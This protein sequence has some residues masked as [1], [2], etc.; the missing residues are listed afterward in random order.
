MED[1]GIWIY[2]IE[3]LANLFTYTAKNRD[4][5]EIVQ[6]VIW[7]ERNDYASFVDHL[8]KCKGMV[9]YNNLA[10]DYPVIHHLLKGI[11][12]MQYWTGDKIT[13]SVYKKA[14]S[15]IKA[16][17]STV[18]E[19]EVM[20]P[21]MDLFAIWHFNNKARITSLK[22]LEIN[23][24]YPN[25]LDMPYHHT[26]KIKTV[27]Q[28]QEILDYNINDVNATEEFYYKTEGKM[29]L[30]RGLLKKYGMKCIN[31]PDSKIGEQLVL[32]LYCEATGLSEAIVKRLR[33]H[34]SLF[35]FAECVPSYIKFR[36][37]PFK[38]MFSYIQSIEVKEL[39]DSFAYSFTSNDFQFDIGTGGIHGCIKAGVYA[40]E[41]QIIIDADVASLYPSLAIAEKLYPAHLGEVFSKVYEDGIVKPR[42]YA[43]EK[44]D[45]KMRDK[46]MA[47]GYKLSANSVYGKSNS[48][49]SFLYDPLYTLKTTLAGQ[50]ALLMLS[51]LMFMKIPGLQMLQ[52]NTDGVTV[53]FD[54]KHID[55]YFKVCNYWQEISKLQLE[56]V[57][58]S[59][60]VIRDVNNY[61]AVSSNEIFF[62][63]DSYIYKPKVSTKYKGTF[64]DNEELR[65]DGEWHKAFSQGIVSTAVNKYFLENIPV[66]KTL[67]ECNDIYEF[68][69]T[70]NTT[71][72]W[73]AETFV[74]DNNDEISDITKQ[75]KNNRYFVSTNGKSFRKCTYKPDKITGEP[76]LTSTEYEAGKKVTIFNKYFELPI[77]KYQIDYEYYV[78]ECYK[79][80]HKIDGTEERMLEEAKNLRDKTKREK[81]EENYL[82]FC[83]NK[84]PTEKQY[85]QYVREWLTDKYG[86][87]EEIK[88]SKIRIS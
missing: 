21:Q 60:M 64:K 11:P 76:K 83:V 39:K 19:E 85:E 65:K 5:K 13:A 87:P 47:D 56:Y 3:T 66:E 36:T 42:L 78:D 4:T 54:R 8:R 73:W 43:K 29:E 31:Y 37:E 75:Q 48:E 25:V 2:D 77:E 10:F 58:Y 41:D 15:V 45:G 50:L 6:F 49:F 44:V 63:N 27:E 12:E 74:C 7:K 22:R 79:L 67:S 55:M 81:E 84:I 20:I 62:E 70:G 23:M 59:K 86:V 14:Q 82:K 32:K 1:K 51:E 24:N 38:E 28:V 34:R 26:T 72:E 9:G 18:K 46:I 35:K 57:E 88:P 52:I 80:I 69:K 30:R 53:K 68:C 71:G 16:E 61:I 40:A 33:T 17:F